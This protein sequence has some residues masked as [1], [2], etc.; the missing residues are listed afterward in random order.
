[1]DGDDRLLSDPLG[2]DNLLGGAGVD[3]QDLSDRTQALLITIG[4]GGRDDGQA[5]ENDQTHP[6]VEIFLTGSGSDVIEDNWDDENT[7]IMGAG[8][9]ILY[10]RR[11]K[12]TV[13][14]GAG[15][16]TL[17]YAPF[18]APSRVYFSV[19]IN[20]PAGTVKGTG[21]SP[22][23]DLTFSGFERFIGGNNNDVIQGGLFSEF[24]AG[25]G[26]NDDIKGGFGG[27][28]IL[29]GGGDDIL[30]GEGGDDKISGEDGNDFLYGDAGE[31]MLTGGLNRDA[32]DG[33]DPTPPD[34]EKD[35]VTDWD[36]MPPPENC[37][38][39]NGCEP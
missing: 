5:D 25:L 36:Q 21:A 17:S 38:N 4:I 14:A 12:D 6:G 7:F 13:N 23:A 20:V 8:N 31:D 10:A 2:S 28:E 29:G 26:G 11:A 33:G 9:D 30:R 24:L 32:F 19:N 16:D 18:E 35:T 34:E 37:A 15:I 39:A 1:M 3:T 27:D 22:N